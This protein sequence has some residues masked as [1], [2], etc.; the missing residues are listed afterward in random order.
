MSTANKTVFLIGPGYI[1]RAVA[2]LLS[3]HGYS[4]TTLVRREA[5]AKELANDGIKAV[6]GD[7]DDK[8]VIQKQAEASDVV[9]HTATA[10]HLPSVEAVL[11]GIRR[12][13]AHD[14]RT[15]Y[16]HTSGASF[17]SDDSRSAYKSD[18]VYSDKKPQALD[19][20]PDSASH[21]SIDLAIIKARK[22]LGTK[23]KVFIVL[24]PLIYGSIPKHGRLSIQIPTM[25]RFALKHRYAGHVGKGQAVWSLVHVSDLARAYMTILHWL[26]RSDDSTALEHPYFFC[27]NG[28]E[29]S[30]GE[31]AAMIGKS[32]HAV[33]KV[34]DPTPREIPEAEWNDLFGP[35]SAVVV[36]AN[37]RNR[38]ERVRELGWQPEHTSITDAFEKEELPVLLQDTSDFHGYAGAAASG[39]TN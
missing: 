28:Q 23:A 13:A 19:A 36:G 31:A 17:L 26:E 6:F 21:R 14:Q 35:Y 24:P 16:I 7:L 22:E 8:E 27:E 33:G 11:D 3:E 4:V 39:A 32:L 5:A 37:A 38:A 18:V 15:I 25:A 29:M 20:R 12:R 9:I 30:W 1:G 34:Q 10:D 2:D